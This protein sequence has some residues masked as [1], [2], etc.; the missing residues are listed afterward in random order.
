MLLPLIVP[1]YK[2]VFWRNDFIVDLPLYDIPNA[3]FIYIDRLTKYCRLMPC[4]VEE[5]ALSASS[6]AKLFFDNTRFFSI[7]TEVISESNPRFVTFF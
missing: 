5:G 4:F 7:F 2:F 6:V 3:F 1:K